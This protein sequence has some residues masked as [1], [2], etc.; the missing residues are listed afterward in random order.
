MLGLSQFGLGN[1]LA[2]L[3]AT[4]INDRTALL[5]SQL[6]PFEA[7]YLGHDLAAGRASPEALCVWDGASTSLFARG[8][9]P[10]RPEPLT[11]PGEA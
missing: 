9:L 5:R 11:G 10:T 8:S 3:T 7:W 1:W 4:I 2:A 6:Y